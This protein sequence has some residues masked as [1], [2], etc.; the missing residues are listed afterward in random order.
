MFSP[1]PLLVGW[2]GLGPAPLLPPLPPAHTLIH[3]THQHEQNAEGE[4]VAI[5]AKSTKAL[6]MNAALGVSGGG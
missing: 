6:L 4:L 2:V 1:A 5:A 3:N